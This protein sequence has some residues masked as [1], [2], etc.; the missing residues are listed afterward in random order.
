MV[1]S[2][3]QA[4]C[5]AFWGINTQQRGHIS[6]EKRSKIFKVSQE[7]IFS[8]IIIPRHLKAEAQRTQFHHVSLELP[9]LGTQLLSLFLRF[10]ILLEYKGFL[11]EYV[12]I[13]NATSTHITLLLHVLI[14]I[15]GE[16]Y[17]CSD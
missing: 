15:L 1:S 2:G 7:D 16:N 3:Y 5:P 17:H 12:R 8:S 6:S 14:Q 10:I 4:T 9:N 11:R 13:T